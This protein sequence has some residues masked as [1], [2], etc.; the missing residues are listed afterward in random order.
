MN[1]RHAAHP[2]P[3]KINTS[4]R[5]NHRAGNLDVNHPGDRYAHRRGNTVVTASLTIGTNIKK[6]ARYQRADDRRKAG[7]PTRCRCPMR[8]ISRKRLGNCGLA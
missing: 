7:R 2:A 4:F 3:A 5:A 1:D 6:A 8:H